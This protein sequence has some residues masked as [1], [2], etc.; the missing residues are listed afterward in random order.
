MYLQGKKNLTSKLLTHIYNIYIWMSN[1]RFKPCLCK[2]Q[3][4]IIP[5]TINSNFVSI[6]AP[7][8]NHPHTITLSL[9]G[10]CHIRASVNPTCTFI[11]YH[12]SLCYP[13]SGILSGPRHHQFSPE[14]FQQAKI[15]LLSPLASP[16]SSTY[17]GFWHSSQILFTM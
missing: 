11:I 8:S 14:L 5:L 4:L 1:K 13:T 15:C 10:I 2:P 16:Y 9:S 3:V 12:P 7:F 17:N 6:I